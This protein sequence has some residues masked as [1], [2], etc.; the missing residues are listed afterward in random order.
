MTSPFIAEIKIFAGNFAPRGYAECNGALL[1]ISSNTALFSL[2]GTFYGGNGSQN[3]ALPNFQGRAPV[4]QSQGPGLSNYVIGQA[5]GTESVTL[6]TTQMPAHTHPPMGGTVAGSTTQVGNAPT[7]G[8]V[9]TNTAPGAAYINSAT[10]LIAM[11]PQM[12]GATGGSQ[13]HE[14]RQPTLTLLFM[15]ATQGVFPTRN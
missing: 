10:S 9:L 8:A 1:S 6:L 2:I 15:I 14:N 11:A 5:S 7:A 3:F 13:P 12:I 4:H